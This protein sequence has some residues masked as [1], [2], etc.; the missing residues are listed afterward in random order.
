MPLTLAVA[1]QGGAPPRPRAPSDTLVIEATS[2]RDTTKRDSTARSDSAKRAAFLKDSLEKF[3]AG[4][5]LRA[6]F[7]H[8]ENPRSLDIGAP[9]TWNREQL[10]QSGAQTLADLLESVPGASG[11]RTAWL[12]D[13]QTGAY[14]G[15]FARVRVFVDGLPFH[16]PD[17]DGHGVLDLTAIQLWQFEQATIERGAT[18]LRIYLRSWRYDKTIAA[19]RVDVFT[20]DQDANT[21]RGYFAQRFGPG[22][23]IQAAGEN[24]S[25]SNT[26]TGGDGARRAGMV[27]VGWARGRWSIDVTHQFS[28]NNRNSQARKLP[29]GAIP[30]W[31]AAASQGYA[32]VAWGDPD[33]GPWVQALAATT[34]YAQQSS[35]LNAT[36]TDTNRVFD[37]RNAMY[38]LQAGTAW[39]A[40]RV[41]GGMRWISSRGTSFASPQARASYELPWIA[42]QAYG[43]RSTEDS[44]T[45]GDVSVRVLPRPWLAIAGSYGLLNINDTIGRRV[46][47][48]GWR[49]ELGLRVRPEL[50]LSGGVLGRDS[51]FVRPATRYDSTFTA[52]MVP[53]AQGTFV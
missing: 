16:P 19:S 1:Q 23:G 42:V 21:F 38:A 37:R 9:F 30:A 17:R 34:A 29:L 6:P 44:T 7:A 41:S 40:L 10:M 39:G 11:F 32:R 28:D 51:A 48:T 49:G 46:R 26:R 3:R 4:D 12:V 25:L 8:A 50:W 31:D 2:A 52:T 14:L 5:T 47:G 33:D 53:S 15:D 20:G 18:E 35:A 27:R 22:L 13:Q 36:L 24:L 45:R 43:E